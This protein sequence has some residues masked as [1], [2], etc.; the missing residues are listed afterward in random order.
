MENPTAPAL[1]FAN[2]NR[3]MRYYHLHK[4]DPEFQH[5]MSEAKRRYYQKN[6]DTIIAKSL[7]RYYA[8]K[9]PVGDGDLHNPTEP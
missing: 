4:T 1:D 5:R 8:N 2:M 3:K 7:A 6:K 9:P